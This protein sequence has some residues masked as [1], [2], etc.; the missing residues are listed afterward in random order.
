MLLH[1]SFADPEGFP[2]VLGGGGAGRELAAL[3]GRWAFY[4]HTHVPALWRRDPTGRVEQLPLPP[5]G[6]ASS[7]DLPGRYLANPGAVG[8]PRD[9]DR[10]AAFGIFDRAGAELR[11]LRVEY[12]VPAAQASIR[13]AGMPLIE[14]ERLERGL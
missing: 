14:A 6:A 5:S 8:Q 10:R 9:G 1:A 3:P 2:Y 12:D 13:R 7:L 11:V 4:G